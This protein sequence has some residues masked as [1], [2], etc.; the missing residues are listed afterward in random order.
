MNTKLEQKVIERTNK[1]DNLLRQKD[2]FINQL[3]LFQKIKISVILV[4]FLWG[5]LLKPLGFLI[6]TPLCLVVALLIMGV[7]SWVKNIA[8]SIIFSFACRSDFE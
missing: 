6:S 2:E 4:S 3:G 7:R 5:W 1:I 8:F